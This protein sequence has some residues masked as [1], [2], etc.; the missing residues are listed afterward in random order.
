MLKHFLTWLAQQFADTAEPLRTTATPHVNGNN[1]Q[2]VARKND[3]VPDEP[4][5]G[6]LHL[7]LDGKGG[8]WLAILRCPCGCGATIQLPM[9]PPARPCWR[10]NGSIQRPNLWPS[11]RRATG[12]KSHFVLRG[13]IVHWCYDR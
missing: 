5:A 8:C 7:I 9:T 11:V 1:V 13:G 4:A 6:V 3:D 10:F 12:C 2:Y